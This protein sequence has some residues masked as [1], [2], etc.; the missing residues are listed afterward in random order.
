MSKEFDFG[1][2]KKDKLTGTDT[3]PEKPTTEAFVIQGIPE[4]IPTGKVSEEQWKEQSDKI[5]AQKTVE[6][7]AP[8]KANPQTEAIH[9]HIVQPKITK[10][11]NTKGEYP[12]AIVE[13]REDDKYLAKLDSNEQLRIIGEI[14]KLKFAVK[15]VLEKGKDYYGKLPTR[16]GCHKLQTIFNIST[17]IVEELYWKDE[18][19]QWIA[20]Y[21]VR[22]I[23]PNGRYTEAMGLCEQNEKGRVR[24]M[25]DTLATAQTRG[26][27][28]AILD[29]VGFGQVSDEEMDDKPKGN[30]GFGA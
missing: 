5:R 11:T 14:N 28:R 29:L 4:E 24:T 2:L 30:G 15:S 27:N 22:A 10:P 12:L 1:S 25:M 23:T 7:G 26:T 8:A 21:K 17:E 19:G 20:K 3:K 18:N 6:F 16:S 13:I 9:D